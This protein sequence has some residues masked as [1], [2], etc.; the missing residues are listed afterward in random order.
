MPLAYR[1]AYLKKSWWVIAIP[2]IFTAGRPAEVQHARFFH[3]ALWPPSEVTHSHRI[4]GGWISVDLVITNRD[5]LFAQQEKE[6]KGSCAARHSRI[7]ERKRKCCIQWGLWEWGSIEVRCT[8]LL[9]RC[10]DLRPFWCLVWA[11]FG[12]KRTSC[13]HEHVMIGTD[14]SQS[15]G[16]RQGEWAQAI[17]FYSQALIAKP[18]WGIV[19]R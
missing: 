1:K 12:C 13:E 2:E 15:V 11:C 19:Y 10:Y 18:D 16:S 5:G 9:P 4:V 14:T 7:T 17:S 8:L 3:F 6:A